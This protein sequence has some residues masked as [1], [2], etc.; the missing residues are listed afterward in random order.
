[1]KNAIQYKNHWLMKSST[2]HELFTAWK[3]Q[4]DP[5]LAKT[6]RKRFEDH[7]KMVLTNYD[8]T[9]K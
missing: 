3:E 4:K 7:F 9:T 1:M 5:V 6:Y 2:A 8:I